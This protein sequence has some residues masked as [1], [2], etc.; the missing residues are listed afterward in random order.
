MIIIISYVV[1]I[2]ISITFLY[3]ITFYGGFNVIAMTVN[4]SLKVMPDMIHSSKS[5][6]P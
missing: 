1:L 3:I 6:L 4:V 2:R 5:V